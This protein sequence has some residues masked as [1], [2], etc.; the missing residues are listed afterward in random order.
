MGLFVHLSYS[1][2]WGYFLM[3]KG[4]LQLIL[5][6]FYLFDFYASWWESWRKN[7]TVVPAKSAWMR[8]PRIQ[9][10]WIQGATVVRPGPQRML[11]MQWSRTSIKLKIVWL[12][13]SRKQRPS[14][15]F[16]YKQNPQADQL[17]F[18]FSVLHGNNTKL[19]FARWTP[20]MI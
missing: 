16:L 1:W 8:S 7:S 18:T 10:M 9:M 4:S 14:L 13:S 15:V 6:C 17:S 20:C 11:T 2:E 5:Q 3:T 12:L 19:P